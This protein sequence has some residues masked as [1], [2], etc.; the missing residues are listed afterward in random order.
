MGA[1]RPGLRG[2]AERCCAARRASSRSRWC[3]NA[4]HRRRGLGLRDLRRLRARVPGVD[5][6]RRPHRRPAPPPRD[7]RVALP[8]RGRADAARRR[9]RRRTRGASRRPSA[10][11]GPR[12]SACACSSRATRR[13]RSST[14]SAARRRSTSARATAARVDGASCCRRPAS[15]S[16]S[17]ARASRAPATRRG[18]WATS[19]SS[20]RYAEQNVATLNEAGVTKIVASCPHCFNTLGNEYPDFGGALRGR[21]PHRAA[22][23]ARARRPARAD[24]GDA[25]RSPTTTPATWPATTTCSSEPRELVAA[26]GQPIEMERSG[27]RTFCCGAGGAHMWMEERGR[28]DQRGARARGGRRPAPRRSRWPAR[29]AR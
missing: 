12:G 20:R 6:A 17:S 25:G 3:P 10:P 1:A 7:G 2:G 5:R 9:A 14:G 23:R 4:V 26:V 27:K 13:P 22:R 11:T 18:G 8:G 21:A 15:T 28:P 24:G 16:R 19:T 29:S